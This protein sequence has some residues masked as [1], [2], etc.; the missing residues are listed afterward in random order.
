VAAFARVVEKRGDVTVVNS[1]RNIELPE[2]KSNATL[3]EEFASWTN[4]QLS[5]PSASYGTLASIK[6]VPNASN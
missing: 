4:P 1:A 6:T 5:P 2:L 3:R